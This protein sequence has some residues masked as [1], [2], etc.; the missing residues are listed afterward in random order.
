MRKTTLNDVLKVIQKWEN[1][2]DVLF[3]GGFVEFDAKGDVKD[4]S[5]FIAYGYKDTIGIDLK[6]FNRL[7]KE[8]KSEFLNW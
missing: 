5:R 7:F 3:H 4:S 6:E 2:N 8:D 1:D